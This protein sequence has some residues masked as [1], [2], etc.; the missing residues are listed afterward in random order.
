L[1]H[2]LRLNPQGSA[3]IIQKKS[4]QLTLMALVI[5]VNTVLLVAAQMDV[6]ASQPL[7]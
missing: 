4:H 5:M 2:N 6:S 7:G 1:G 3:E